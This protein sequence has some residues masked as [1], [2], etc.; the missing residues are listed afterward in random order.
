MVFAFDHDSTVDVNLYPSQEAVPL[1][2]VP[3]L[4]RVLDA[5]SHSLLLF[6]LARIARC[7][8]SRRW[9]E[10]NEGDIVLSSRRVH[11]ALNNQRISS[12]WSG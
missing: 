12:S 6:L 4:A 5:H 3:Q 1:E 11:A 10:G 8:G 7:T 9:T 2:W